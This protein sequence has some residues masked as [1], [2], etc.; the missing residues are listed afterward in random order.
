MGRQRSL[1]QVLESVSGH[2]GSSNLFAALEGFSVRPDPAQ[3]RLRLDANAGEQVLLLSATGNR[4][5]HGRSFPPNSSP[6]RDAVWYYD[7][8][9]EFTDL[10][11]SIPGTGKLKAV[12]SWFVAEVGPAVFDL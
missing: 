10:T 12:L 8:E 1:L 9:A 2:V 6:P 4:K 11:G 3:S 7:L 5:L